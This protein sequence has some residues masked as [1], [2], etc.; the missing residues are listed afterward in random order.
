M[1]PYFKKMPSFGRELNEG[2]IKSTEENVQQIKEVETA[3]RAAVQKVKT[4]GFPEEKINARGQ[5]T[6]WQRINYLIDPGTWCPLHTLFN[7]ENNAERPY[8]RF[9]RPG[10]DIRQMVRGDRFR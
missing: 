4:A 2:Q 7:P 8:Q 10:Q 6:V 1:R 9:R 3:V 5:M